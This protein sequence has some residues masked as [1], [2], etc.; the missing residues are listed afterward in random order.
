VARGEGEHL[1]PL[2]PAAEQLG[3]LEVALR[4]GGQ[5]VVQALRKRLAV[6]P[7]PG[8][9]ADRRH[10]DAIDRRVVGLLE[11]GGNVGVVGLEPPGGE[12]MPV[13]GLGVAQRELLVAEPQVDAGRP[14]AGCVLLRRGEGVEGQG[15]PV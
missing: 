10:Q 4:V 15:D 3:E 11:P 12:E 14:R 2:L 13:G 1:H 7:D 8:L 6:D 9:E 5:L